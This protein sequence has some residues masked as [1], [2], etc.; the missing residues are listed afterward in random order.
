MTIRDIVL[1]D[2]VEIKAALKSK[3]DDVASEKLDPLLT[4]LDLAD[5]DLQSWNDFLASWRE[6]AALINDVYDVSYENA[7]YYAKVM[8]MNYSRNYWLAYE[9]FL[10]NIISLARK[11]DHPQAN[12]L[13]FTCLQIIEDIKGL[14]LMEKLSVLAL[15]KDDRD[16]FI[17]EA[18]KEMADVTKNLNVIERVL[19]NADVSKDQLSAFNATFSK[20]GAGK[21]KF[22]ERGTLSYSLTDFTRPPNF[23]NPELIEMSSIYWEE[24]KP[25][26]GGGTEIFNHIVKLMESDSSSESHQKLRIDEKAMLELEK[27][28]IAQLVD[29]SQTGLQL[30][31]Q[32]AQRSYSRCLYIMIA[33]AGLGLLLGVVSSILYV[34]KLRFTLRKL[35]GSLTERSKQVE[36]LAARLNDNAQSLGDGAGKNAES[37]AQTSSA[38][39]EL[40]SMTSRNA[41]NSAEADK[42]MTEATDSVMTAQASMENVIEAMGEISVS[43]NEISKIIKSIDEVAFQTNLLALNAAVEAARAG[44]AG[45]GFAVVAQEVRN[46][47]TRSADAA[48]NTAALIE[49]TINNI[50]SGSYMVTYTAETF[51]QVSE[52]SSKIAGLIGEVAEASKEQAGGISKITEEISEM[53]G[54]TQANVASAGQSASIASMLRQEGEKLTETIMDIDILVE[55]KSA[56]K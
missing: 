29:R 1:T 42:L 26:R 9:P 22:G 5:A 45:A 21:M 3:L 33:T 49:T 55:G 56:A 41:V 40:S 8:S 4:A 24:I 32:N 54:I 47:A 25:L 28:R 16:K 20:A 35:S 48:K 2:N 23:L 46:L 50:T 18:R 43:G 15:K 53:D 37:L 13:A 30:D 19:T 12:D 27:H 39:E 52:N 11:S 38:L 44:E 51:N 34:R 14:Q 6:H 31:I 10:R 17:E 36:K 7:A